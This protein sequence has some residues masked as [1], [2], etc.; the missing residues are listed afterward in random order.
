MSEEVTCSK[1]IWTVPNILS[2]VRLVLIP[3]IIWLYCFEENFI[4]TA[5][6]LFF[7]G[8]T[9]VVDGFIARKFNMVSELGKALDPVAD[10]LTQG[11]M[12]FCLVVRFPHMLI[13]PVL[14]AVKELL[15]AITGILAAKKTGHV[16]G[17][18]WHGKLN[19]VLLYAMMLMHVLWPTIPLEISF[20]SVGVCIMMMIISLLMYAQRN[21]ALIKKGEE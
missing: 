7:S 13:P 17:A 6:I 12:L 1:K 14:M 15:M 19:T 10:K 21:L 9:D 3:F 20:F 16:H 18:E 5:I 11:A 8:V 4:W 2:M